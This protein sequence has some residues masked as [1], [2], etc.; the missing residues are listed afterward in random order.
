MLFNGAIEHRFSDQL[1]ATANAYFVRDEIRIN[2]VPF[3]AFAGSEVDRIPD[4]VRGGEL[5]AVYTWS[6][7][8][9]SWAK[10]F[11][12]LVGFDFKDRWVR[13][14]GSDVFP[15]STTPPT[16]LCST[17]AARNMPGTSN[18]RLHSFDGDLLGTGRLRVDGNSQFGKEVSPSWSVAIPTR[19]NMA[20]PCAAAI[21]KAFARRL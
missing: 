13:D 5:N 2:E 18:R 7:Q 10:G 15:P 14:F 21:A 19:E 6:R 12:T 1:V 4:E 11:R 8:E 17:R 9:S 3:A 20:S 16:I